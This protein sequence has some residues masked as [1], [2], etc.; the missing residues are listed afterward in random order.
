MEGLAPI[1]TWVIAAIVTK[2][3]DYGIALLAIGGP[4]FV[5]IFRDAPEDVLRLARTIAIASALLSIAVLA[6]RFGIRSARISGAGMS[7]MTD[8]L[9]LR[10]IWE[11]PFGSAAVLRVLGVLFVLATASR[12]A[13]ASR[14]ALIGSA[15]I[16]VSYAQ[17]GHSLGDPR[18]LLAGLVSVHLLAAGFWVAA[19]VPLYRATRLEAGGTL[20]HHFGTVASLTVPVLILVGLI[21]AWVM[22]GSFKGLFS[23]AYG[24]TLLLK[25]TFVAG[26]FSL[27]CLNKLRLVPALVAGEAHTVAQL[28]RSIRLEALIVLLILVATAALTTITTPPVNL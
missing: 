25:V 28:R 23:T 15:L 3:L 20:L 11:S 18:W 10:L 8:P 12:I 1:D 16:A 19:F 9:M 27:A 4:L 5:F 26:L 21:F 14:L 6:L 17:V 13:A 24:W 22:T 7:G 2:T